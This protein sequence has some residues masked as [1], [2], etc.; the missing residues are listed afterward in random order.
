MWFTANIRQLTPGVTELVALRDKIVWRK[1][2]Q[3]Q[4]DFV[5][6]SFLQHLL[7]NTQGFF[8]FALHCAFFT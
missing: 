2:G 6:K 8:V 3:R 4:D 7:S 5:V 1:S